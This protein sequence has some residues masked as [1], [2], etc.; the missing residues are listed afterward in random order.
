MELHLAR[1]HSD[2]PDF[3]LLAGELEQDLR[4]RDGDRY[5]QHALINAIDQ[6]PHTLVVYEREQPVAC[7]AIRDYEEK[8][9]EIKRMYV[10]PASRGKGIAT[11]LLAEL[12]NWAREQGYRTCV[13]E[14]GSNQPE[15]IA[16]YRKNGYRD[17][18]RFGR[19]RDSANSVC[20]GKELFPVTPESPGAPARSAF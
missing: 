16:L 1:T 11:A 8:T 14:T 3:R 17:I 4:I 7:G 9:V 20:F 2:D 10:R 6:L 18:P 12:E 15:A 13:L 5:E 19:Y